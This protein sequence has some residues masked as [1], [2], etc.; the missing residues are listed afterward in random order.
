[1]VLAF[2]IIVG[3]RLGTIIKDRMLAAWQRRA[4]PRTRLTT[5]LDVIVQ[6]LRTA[7]SYEW[8]IQRLKYRIAP[9]FF[10]LLTIY[11]VGAFVSHLAFY[12][13]DAAG[14]PCTPSP[15]AK[16]LGTGQTS[17]KI[18]FN[19]S[20]LC[21]ATGISLS[22][23]TRYVITIDNPTGWQDAA[24]ASDLGGYDINALPTVWDRAKMVVAT[25]L[26]RVL[27]R[28]WFRV[29]A[30]VGQAGTDEYFLDPDA[31]SGV[32]RKLE[33]PFYPHR[34]GELYLYVN[35]AVLPIFMKVFYDN[36][37]GTATVTVTQRGPTSH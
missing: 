26:R 3:L 28:P 24:Y 30:R 25:P 32:V 5:T 14:L 9:A 1:L 11:A 22:A 18:T 19:A 37:Q 27:L 35:D 15:D 20:S 29:I 4:P 12:F 6:G 36:N 21:F 31:G 17:E 13:E 8:C 16:A 2:F 34:S 10:A 33:V 23:G 7:P